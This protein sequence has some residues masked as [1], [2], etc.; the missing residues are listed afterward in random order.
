MANIGY[1]S[2]FISFLLSF[3]AIIALVLGKRINNTSL[4][5]SGKGAI[6]A[7]ALLTLIA[8]FALEYLLLISDF[9]IKYVNQY[10]STDLATMYK[11]S[12]LWAGNDGSLLLWL[13]VLAIYNAVIIYQNKIKDMTPYVASMLA[14]NSMFFLFILVFVTNPFEALGYVPNEGQGLNPML[15]NPGMIIHPV[16]TYL[17]YVGFAVPFAFAMT[18]LILRK[19]DDQWIKVTRHWTIWAWLFLTWGNISGGQWAYEELGWGGY[20]AWD[21]V[22]NASFLPW[23]TG[24]AFLH[25]VMIQ[26]RKNMLKIWNVSLI[27]VTFALT[28]FGTFL[29]RSGILTSVHAF[30]NSDLGKFFLAFTVLVITF[31]AY[32]IVDRL[33]V[34][35]EEREF[36][37]YVS[38]ESSFLLNNLLL[39]G[40]AFATLWGT[41]FPLLSEAVTG[42]KIT[43]S[44]PFFNTVNAPIGL[45]MVFLMGVCPLIAWRKSSLKNIRENFMIPGGLALVF[46]VMGYILGITK[47]YSLLGFTIS[48][49]VIFATLSE[50]I[51][52]TAVRVK[53]TGENVFVAFTKLILRNRRR[54]GGYLVHLGVIMVV[55]GI[56]GSN[57]YDLVVDK[58]ASIGETIKVGGYDIKYNNLGERKVASKGNYDEVYASLS[59]YQDGKYVAQMEPSKIFYPTHPNPATKPAIRSMVK[60]DLYIVLAGWEKDSKAVFSVRINPLVIW[61]WIGGYIMYAGGIFALWP[62]RGNQVGPKYTQRS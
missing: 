9:S 59:I 48:A 27:S 7:I 35:K 43:V 30:G 18:A 40:I 39:L 38:K 45:A 2:L 54:Y 26:E 62:G 13:V 17:G 24:S 50:F 31:S 47:L 55:I 3:Y 46:G 33:N 57:S 6:Y 44:T 22:E 5:K 11:A 25:S 32:L 10:T 56:I 16:T 34:L 60:E 14:G 36:E 21:P 20:W 41:T 23:L 4:I 58:T 19:T 42:N 15:V 8:T 51:K 49:F 37:S 1:L 28:L 29:V 52:G 53:M 61:I 12:A